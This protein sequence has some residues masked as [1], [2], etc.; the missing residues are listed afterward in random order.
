MKRFWSKVNVAGPDECW[1]WQAGRFS[2]GYGQF[3]FDGQSRGAH[4]VA[5]LLEVGEIENGMSV[6]HSCDNPLCVNPLHL[7]LG[8][9]K[10][11]SQDMASKNRQRNQGYER[12]T[13]VKLT[14]QA[15]RQIRS[16]SKRQKDLAVEF[17]VSQSSISLIQ[18]N[19]VWKES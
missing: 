4:R 3:Y 5:Y 17:G 18:R 1:E 14:W 13:N 11:N 6:C 9:P 16:S 19:E 12:A 7:W 8:T 15:V 10:E 2:T